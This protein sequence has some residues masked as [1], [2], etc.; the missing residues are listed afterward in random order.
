MRQINL[1]HITLKH[2]RKLVLT[3]LLA[4]AFWLTGCAKPQSPT[5]TNTL[6]NGAWDNGMW[7]T[8]TWQ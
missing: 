2:T 4:L 1:K 8:S 6:D 5:N 7:D 3:L